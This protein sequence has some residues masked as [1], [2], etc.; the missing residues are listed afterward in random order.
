MDD[1]EVQI[2]LNKANA[3][4]KDLCSRLQQI[5]NILDE[6]EANGS[7]CCGCLLTKRIR[8]IIEPD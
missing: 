8:E 2:I 6:E 1:K 4:T 3:Y 5:S 7:E